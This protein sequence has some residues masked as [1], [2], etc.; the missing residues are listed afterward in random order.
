MGSQNGRDRVVLGRL[1]MVS[2]CNVML[3]SIVE[4]GA[5]LSQYPHGTR[6]RVDLRS[7]P[8]VTGPSGA[9][10]VADDF[11]VFRQRC[12]AAPPASTGATSPGG[13]PSPELLVIGNDRYTRFSFLRTDVEQ[14]RTACARST[15]D[16]GSWEPTG[17]S[18][19]PDHETLYG[20]RRIVVRFE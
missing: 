7:S 8:N 5:M 6:G 18:A 2:T 14:S 9:A 12:R 11:A 15:S 16:A 4:N 10:S 20:H 3:H 17:G 19:T 13:R 1:G